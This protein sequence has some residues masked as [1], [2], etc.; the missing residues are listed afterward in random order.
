M[1]DKLKQ[2]GVFHEF[3]QWVNS[4][5]RYH[6]DKFNIM[7]CTRGSIEQWRRANDYELT[8]L[9]IEFLDLK[10]SLCSS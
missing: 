9:L 7:D 8:G 4:N 5:T 10:K 3:T 1:I 2:M 6:W